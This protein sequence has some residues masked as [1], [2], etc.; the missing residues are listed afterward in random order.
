[1]LRKARQH[2]KKGGELRLV[3][4]SFLRYQPLIEEQFGICTVKAEGQ[5][6]RIYRA[7]RA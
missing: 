7:K 1:L 6:F 2:L 3:A 4:N 5:G